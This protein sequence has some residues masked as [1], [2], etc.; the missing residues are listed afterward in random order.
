MN[1]H[2]MQAMPQLAGDRANVH[3]QVKQ[4]DSAQHEKVL[5]LEG[6]YTRQQVLVHLQDGWMDTPVEAGHFVN[7]IA[8]KSMDSA[9]I[10]HAVCNF[11]SGVYCKAKVCIDASAA[12][13]QHLN[14]HGFEQH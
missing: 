12:A 13:A 7:L 11:E 2:D 1:D 14:V 4:V 10:V 5:H 9:G 8:E 6:A 3:F